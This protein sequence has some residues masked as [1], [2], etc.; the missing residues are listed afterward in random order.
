[1]YIY[2]I[3]VLFLI[4]AYIAYVF[5]MLF[6]EGLKMS[7]YRF[8]RDWATMLACTICALGSIGNLYFLG[9]TLLQLIGGK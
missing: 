6:M 9:T 5:V 7:D 1:M 8:R 3:G 2:L 4:S